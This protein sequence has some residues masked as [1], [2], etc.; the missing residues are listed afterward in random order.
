M[1]EKYICKHCNYETNRL[2][3]YTRHLKSKKH[4][5]ISE[6]PNKKKHMYRTIKMFFSAKRKSCEQMQEQNTKTN[7]FQEKLK[8]EIKELKKIIKE[9][10]N[11]I[12]NL[13]Q[14]LNESAND[15]NN[16]LSFATEAVKTTKTIKTIVINNFNS[17]KKK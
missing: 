7:V 9:K 15:K 2:F 1:S 17:P 4:L 8:K 12:N 16:I 6:D 11:K 13:K 10:D 14:K 5:H 3:C